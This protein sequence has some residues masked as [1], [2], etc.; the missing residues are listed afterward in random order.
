MGSHR[1]NRNTET[2]APEPTFE[3]GITWSS[4]PMHKTHFVGHMHNFIYL[5]ISSILS[6]INERA[7]RDDWHRSL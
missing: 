6:I 7:K 3:D 4:G 2:C 1:E 5:Q